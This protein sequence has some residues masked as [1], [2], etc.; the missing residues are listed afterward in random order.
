MDKNKLEAAASTHIIND[1]SKQVEREQEARTFV[2]DAITEATSGTDS[3]GD[4]INVYQ[5]WLV[6][7]DF[8]YAA[9]KA[10]EIIVETPF[11]TIW[12]R[13]TCGQLVSQDINVQNILKAMHVI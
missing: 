5:W 2:A 12:G 1:M 9:K 4:A 10:D 8:S 7:D 6:S 3:E 11:G 13:Q